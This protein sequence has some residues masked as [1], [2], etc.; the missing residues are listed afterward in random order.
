[1]V[2]LPTS[3]LTGETCLT[4]RDLESNQGNRKMSKAILTIE[5]TTEV[6]LSRKKKKKQLSLE[7]VYQ[8]PGWALGIEP[9][10]ELELKPHEVGAA[11]M[12]SL[13]E[14]ETESQVS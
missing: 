10:A 12:H 9:F 6:A 5:K 1:M 14:E 4:A 7:G 11:F 2:L 8:A 13:T 3:K